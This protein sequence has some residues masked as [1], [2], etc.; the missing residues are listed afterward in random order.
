MSRIQRSVI[1]G[2]VLVAMPR[3]AAAQARD[4]DDLADDIARRV[5]RQVDEMTRQVERQADQMARRVEIQAD[6]FARLVEQRFE[7]QGRRGGGSGRGPEYTENF[8]R[9]VRIGRTGALDLQNVAGDISVTGGGG[10]DVRIEAVKRV[11]HTN[12]AEAK[13]L[14]SEIAIE[15]ADRGG[16][17]EVRTEYP[18]RRN[19]SG[20]VDFTL[21][22]P[23]DASVALRSVSGT[24]KVTNINGELRAETVSGDIIMM[25]AKKLR[26][27]KTVSGD[28]EISES[29]ADELSLGTV[30]GDVIVN[31]LK[32][33][34]FDAQSVSGDLRLTDVEI[35][36]ASIRSV[37]GD[38]DYSGRLARN[39]R[40]Q[41]QSHSGDIRVTPADAKGFAIEASTFS[42]DVR[43]DYALTLQ[44][45][46]AN[47]FTP[48]RNRSVR[49]SFG[50]AGATLT[51]QSFSGDIVIVK[52]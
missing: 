42:G 25:T 19:W 7:Q 18:R 21:S 17:V 45:S 26:V 36:H 3:F 10:D 44:T 46:P 27:A 8:S 32:G 1:V 30:S 35:D 31:R 48:G 40:Y 41:F 15:V 9:T 29:A 4:W 23:R 49:G 38:I 22:V 39:G 2:L 6:Q 28:V 14:L 43:S 47:S 37:S 20:G 13:V 12:E 51:L 5:E 50:D 34:G 33:S 52:R 11:R 24:V 16:R